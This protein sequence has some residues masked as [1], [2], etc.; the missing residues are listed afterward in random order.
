MLPSRGRRSTGDHA[1]G[2]K[3]T[4][5]HKTNF[6]SRSSGLG[7][8]F[9]LYIQVA[10]QCRTV[11]VIGFG[12]AG[13]WCEW[14]CIWKVCFLPPPP[15][16]P[17]PTQVFQIVARNV[18]EITW[19]NGKSQANLIPNQW[20]MR[21]KR[22]RNRTGSSQEVPMPILWSKRSHFGGSRGHLGSPWEPFC[23]TWARLGRFFVPLGVALDPICRCWWLL[24]GLGSS[25]NVF[26]EHFW[27]H[28]ASK[29]I[30]KTMPKQVWFRIRKTLIFTTRLQ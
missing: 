3:K 16:T 9:L 12:L 2:H 10:K 4:P 6:L 23:T 13:I 8:N 22:R 15:P 24:G 18:A 11:P 30:E 27:S 26:L 25:T 1:P 19:K 5:P 17:H 21:A 14:R 28:S 29:N 20:K 7:F